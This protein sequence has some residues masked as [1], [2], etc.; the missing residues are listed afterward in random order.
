[1]YL[2][3]VDLFGGVWTCFIYSFLPEGSLLWG[4]S[5]QNPAFVEQFFLSTGSPRHV[6]SPLSGESL[7]RTLICLK[8]SFCL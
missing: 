1:M 8:S 3:C 5:F 2:G 7:F 6:G 4:N